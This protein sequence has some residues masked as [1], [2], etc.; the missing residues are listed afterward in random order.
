MMTVFC[1]RLNRALMSQMRLCNM[2]V[3]FVSDLVV[4]VRQKNSYTVFILINAQEA[5]QFKSLKMT[6]WRQNLG[7][8]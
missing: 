8:K 7:K 1:Q 3:P 4:F 5:L 2:I 6:F